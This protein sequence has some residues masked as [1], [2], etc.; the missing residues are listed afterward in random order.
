MHPVF[1]ISMQAL[2]TFPLR[3]AGSVTVVILTSAIGLEKWKT[4]EL[5]ATAAAIAL[6]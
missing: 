2:L 5:F 6:S 1:F 4:R 3:A